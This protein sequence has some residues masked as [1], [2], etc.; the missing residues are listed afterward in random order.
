MLFILYYFN[1]LIGKISA[2]V[3]AESE[4]QRPGWLQL[5]HK[6]FKLWRE[7]LKYT[8]LINKLEYG[9]CPGRSTSLSKLAHKSSNEAET[10]L[11][12]N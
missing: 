1:K 7:S 8:F 4:F 6:P 2:A 3:A 9:C 12:R 10:S 5:K 11:E